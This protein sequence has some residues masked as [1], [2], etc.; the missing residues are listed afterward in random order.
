MAN[1]TVNRY[2]NIYIQT[3]EAQ[4]ALDKL[5]E[6]EKKLNEE[7]AKSPS[8]VK[9]LKEELAALQEPID[10]ARKKVSGELQPSLKDTETA[11]RK[12]RNELKAMSETD[13]GFAE[14]VEQLKEANS[15]LEAYKEKLG[16]IKDAQKSFAEEASVTATGVLMADAIEGVFDKVKESLTDVVEKT[17]KLSDEFS[18]IRKTT[19]L[20]KEEI[21]QLNKDLSK[22]DTRTSREELR[23]LAEEGGKLGKE[24]VEDIRSFVEEAD[25]I[26]VALGEDLGENALTDIAK[27]SQIFRVE[28]L[29][30]ASAINE[31][32]ASSVASETYSV[33]FLKRMAGVAPTVRLTAQE[34][35]GYSAALE[36]AGQTQEVAA[37]ALNTFM[38]DFVKG[39]EDFGK[40]AGFARGELS[41][42]I[43][44]KGTNEAFLTWLQNLRD[45]NPEADKFLLKLS[46]LGV[47]AAR[48]SNVLLALAN[49]IGTVRDQQEIAGK[50]IQSTSSI[51]DEFNEK[52]NNAAATLDKM[53]K[54]LTA[55]YESPFITGI[56]TWVINTGSKFVDI[57]LKTPGFIKENAV[58]VMSLVAGL[59]LL[60]AQWV[61]NTL[62][63]AK[64]AVQQRLLII[65][66]KA[67]IL[68]TEGLTL[69]KLAWAVASNLLTGNLTRAAAAMRLFNAAA[70]ANVL[71]VIITVV[72]TAILLFEAFRDRTQKVSDAMTALSA[73]N[74]AAS[75]IMRK[76][77][78]MY[79][80]SIA[81]ITRLR[82]ILSDV[83]AKYDEKKRALDKL[84]QINPAF[85]NTLK[86]SKDGHL[87]GV[88][89]IN[90]YIRALKRKALAEAAEAVWR[91]SYQKDIELGADSGEL[92][93]KQVEAH[94]DRM[95]NHKKDARG[96]LDVDKAYAEA[97]AK[98][99]ADNIREITANTK[100]ELKANRAARDYADGLIKKIGDTS[101]IAAPNQSGLTSGG[102]G[103]TEEERKK[104]EA[105]EKRRKKANDKKNEQLKKAEE[106]WAKDL[107]KIRE[108]IELAAMSDDQ[109][110]LQRVE[111]KYKELY[112]KAKKFGLDS[113]ELDK[114][115]AQELAQIE[116]KQKQD[117]LD[118]ENKDAYAKALQ[119]NETLINGRK[120][121]NEKDFA[122]GKLLKE[123]YEAQL[124][125]I[126]LDGQEMRYRIALLYKGLV[127]DADKDSVKEFEK[128]E[129]DKTNATIKQTKRRKEIEN[130][131][132][133]AQAKMDVL[134]TRPLTNA[135]LNAKLNEQKV[136]FDIETQ[137]MDKTSAAY[138]LK[139]KE[140]Q[141]K[142]RELRVQHTVDRVDAAAQVAQ[143]AFNIYSTFAQAQT[144]RENAELESYKKANDKKKEALQDRLN[145]GLISQ[146]EY[147]RA[148][149][150]MDKEQDKRAHELAVKQ[151][152][153]NQKMQIAST[154]MSGA[155]AA[156]N[157][158]TVQPAYVGLA[159]AVAAGIK[160]I[161]EVAMIAKQ[162][163]PEYGR[164]G[165]LKGPSHAENKGM[166]VVDPH[167]N[168]PQAYLEGNEG[169]I[170]KRT[171]GDRNT[172][173]VTGTPSQI[174]SSLNSWHGGVHWES[175]ATMRPVWRM[176]KPSP[177]NYNGIRQAYQQKALYAS[178]GL[179]NS[180]STATD[181]GN[182]Q[183]NNDAMAAMFMQMQANNQMLADTIAG[184]QRNG[185]PAFTLLS[186]QQRQ[187]KRMDDIIADATMK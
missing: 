152:R 16:L 62:N 122:D 95:E 176:P 37:T 166:P 187:Q 139:E 59:A 183:Q 131:N 20:E 179:Y 125:K 48:G 31:V 133:A 81:E 56:G 12:L 86:L 43:N 113:L 136:L 58:A 174:A 114:Y 143:A 182:T 71:G 186:D 79:G 78:Q 52:N 24:G 2:L 41:Q 101:G 18:D 92:I 135:N 153:R 170:N 118:K 66:Q 13:A 82:N 38:L 36:G 123:E 53:K 8:N 83:N 40:A 134:N 165:K 45:L 120:A 132:K 15:E 178:G 69:A 128:W 14:K 177:M 10:R 3:G 34:V 98:I 99:A 163:P 85:V 185:I 51:M 47:D 26:K 42:M 142:L 140:L 23:K 145:A 27:T 119:D 115:K 126:E 91:E 60:N 44:E 157:M 80:D 111:N 87:Q 11:A 155:Q 46:D 167:T 150:R 17:A 55:V 107:E 112:A 67:G 180:T 175:G 159:L 6:K 156:I 169:I 105:E 144:D 181:T 173:T 127:D 75:D 76:S 97:S 90:E 30:I 4:K 84:V 158:L 73:R 109:K 77:N 110:E 171:M 124:S 129:E 96:R 162:K 172:Y 9:K 32:G 25:K 168:I 74:K 108:D 64:V 160:T 63:M 72:S 104:R 22:I 65:Q 19:G 5:Q 88:E 28:M 106:E 149:S 117:S 148:V 100:K 68:V 147:D 161:A 7:I 61:L 57:L 39:A 29:N 151:F 33:D 146:Q 154:L 1:E 54:Q 70:K 184:L 89:A 141:Q 93:N 50:A 130:E 21:N 164:G 116:K 102:T 94:K 137:G 103:E 35:L 121:Q 138:L 49:N